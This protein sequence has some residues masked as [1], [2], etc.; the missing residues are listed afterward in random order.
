MRRGFS[1]YIRK[2]EGLGVAK[3]S[4]GLSLDDYKLPGAMFSS[5]P[6]FLRVFK[7]QDS[8]L[9]FENR[10]LLLHGFSWDSHSLADEW[11]RAYASRE[12]TPRLKEVVNHW[13]TLV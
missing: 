3:P 9:G 2:V 13:T 12:L 5:F 10:E 11:N 7:G 6:D 8:E 1:N 4:L